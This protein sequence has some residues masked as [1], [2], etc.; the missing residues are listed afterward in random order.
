M[1][2][3]PT[4]FNG[5][6]QPFFKIIIWEIIKKELRLTRVLLGFKI[7]IDLLLTI[8]AIQFFHSLSFLDS[9]LKDYQ[10]VE[11]FAKSPRVKGLENISNS[12]RK[13]KKCLLGIGNII[14]NYGCSSLLGDNA[15]DS[16]KAK[17]ALIPYK[18]FVFGEFNAPSIY[19]NF[20]NQSI[21]L[22][23]LFWPFSF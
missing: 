7:Q 23:F 8:R 16:K 4:Y 3:F 9:L 22:T 2:Y 19:H 11:S 1:I 17:G 10:E 6:I 12:E 5:L 14:I 18:H 15:Y 20:E 21:K 13:I